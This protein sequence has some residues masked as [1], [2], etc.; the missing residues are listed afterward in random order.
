MLPPGIRARVEKDSWPVP[1][2][3]EI[4]RGI[5]S[6]DE[7]DMYGTFNMGIGMALVVE[8]GSENEIAHYFNVEKKHPYKLHIIGELAEGEPGVELC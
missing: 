2:I 5:G 6:I 1:P 3:F 7:K 8:N 4:L